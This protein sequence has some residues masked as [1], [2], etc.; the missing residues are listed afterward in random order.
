[1]TLD[2]LSVLHNIRREI[3][4]DR[5][6]LEEL[7]QSGGTKA[8]R[9]AV[10]AIIETKTKKL[11]EERARL[12]SWIAGIPDSMVRQIFTRRFVDGKSWVQVAV[13]IGGDNTADTVRMIAKRYA[14][15][16]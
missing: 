7:E 2:E 12:E 15:R 14:R 6:R 10:R 9:G 16:M 3:E 5:R 8:Q 11:W 4:R 13:E 1:M